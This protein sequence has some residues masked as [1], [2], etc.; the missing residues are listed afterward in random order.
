MVPDAGGLLEYLHRH[1]PDGEYTAVYESGFSGFST[2]YSLAG[3][4]IRCI[5][6]H[7]ADIP[8]TQYEETM[9]TDRIDA[10]KLARCLKVGLLNGIYVRPRESIDDRS[11]VRIRK[12][13]QDQLCSNRVRLIH[14]LHSNGV[15]LPSR[16]VNHGTLWSRAFISWLRDDVVLLSQTRT[17]LDLLLMQVESMRQNLLVAARELRKLSLTERY[18]GNFRLL[19]SIPGIGP[20]VSMCILTELGDIGRF[21]NERE[22]AS[23]LGLIPTCH[24]SGEKVAHGEKT[25][26]GN[27]KVGPML[28]P[29]RF[30]D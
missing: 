10:E 3:C 15:E 13:I 5:I 22:F 11:V 4:G 18:S 25:F 12:T 30:D 7:A 28:V 9:K 19:R 29:Y 23:Y 16:F 14:L 17:S 6:A 27:K 2:Y 21:R 24:S 8:T 26:R 1:Y 20:V